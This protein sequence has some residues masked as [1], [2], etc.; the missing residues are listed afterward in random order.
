MTF[1]HLKAFNYS[2]VDCEC[3]C[4]HLT[5]V[6]WENTFNLDV[7]IDIYILHCEYQV[8]FY[9]SPWFPVACNAP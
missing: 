1:F 7:G 9:L 4:D 8:T 2:P 6:P 5:D 3:L